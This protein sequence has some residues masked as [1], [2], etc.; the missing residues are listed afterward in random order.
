MQAENDTLR[1]RLESKNGE[2]ESSGTSNGPTALQKRLMEL[3][4]LLAISQSH[5]AALKEKSIIDSTALQATSVGVKRDLDTTSHLLQCAQ[6]TIRAQEVLLH[7][8]ILA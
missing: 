6:N 4:R 8:G 3:E 2:S 5:R 1:S 7:Q